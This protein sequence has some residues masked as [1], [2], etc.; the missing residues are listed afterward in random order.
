MGIWITSCNK[1][2]DI[3]KLPGC[4]FLLL[5]IQ[6]E[7]CTP[8]NYHTLCTGGVACTLANHVLSLIVL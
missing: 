5:I 6:Q 2:H 8:A 4:S 1:L 7:L 3:M